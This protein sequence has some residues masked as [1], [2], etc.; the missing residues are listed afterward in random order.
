MDI[1]QQLEEILHQINNELPPRDRVSPQQIGA[2]GLELNAMLTTATQ[3]TAGQFE[4]APSQSPRT[5]RQK[6]AALW[7]TIKDKISEWLS[8]VP[9]RWTRFMNALKAKL[10]D[11]QSRPGN[12]T[13]VAVGL[14]AVGIA[15]AAVLVKSLPLLVALLAILGFTS[16]VN[17]ATRVSRIPSMI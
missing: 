3:Q 5:L 9:P 11:L 15:V 1:H 17:L 7:Q 6:L 16:L 10:Q 8:P 4:A 2:V 12:E 14:M 13:L